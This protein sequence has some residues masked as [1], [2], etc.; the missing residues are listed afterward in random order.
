MTKQLVIYI[1]L[2]FLSVALTAQ[3]DKTDT[4]LFPDFF[5]AVK[6]NHPV[7]KLANLQS[8][9]GNASVMQ[10]RGNF[11]PQAYSYLDNKF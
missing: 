9:R 7:V 10:A 11:D 2:C 1:S 5:A 6:K 3:N 8:A 4:L